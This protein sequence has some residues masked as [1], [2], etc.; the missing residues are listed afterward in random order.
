MLPNSILEAG[1]ISIAENVQ[2][3]V[4]NALASTF[5]AV[6]DGAIAVYVPGNQLD[7]LFGHGLPLFIVIFSVHHRI[8][9]K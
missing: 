9:V 8:Y 5:I 6:H 7:G 3:D 2:V 4:K 1:S